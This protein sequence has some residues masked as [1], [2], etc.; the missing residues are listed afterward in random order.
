[1]KEY[2]IMIEPKSLSV[3]IIVNPFAAPVN[4]QELL[5]D[6]SDDG[7]T[8]PTRGGNIVTDALTAGDILARHFLF[9]FLSLFFDRVCF[10]CIVIFFLFM[11]LFLV[12]LLWMLRYFYL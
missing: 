8:A 3:N 10:F 11:L 9:V 6:T 7:L 5:V 4:V 12:F 1:M 2:S